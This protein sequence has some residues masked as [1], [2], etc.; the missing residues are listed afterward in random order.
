MGPY[1]GLDCFASLAMTG[2]G[3]RLSGE[4]PRQFC[5]KSLPATPL[6]SEKLPARK[7]SFCKRS[8]RMAMRAVQST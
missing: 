5:G 4:S 8:Q 6:R 7:S 3:S 1:R 2:P